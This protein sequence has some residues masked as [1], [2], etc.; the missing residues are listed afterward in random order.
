[1]TQYLSLGFIKHRLGAGWAA[2]GV[3]E[4]RGIPEVGTDVARSGGVKPYTALG[5]TGMAGTGGESN[6]HQDVSMDAGTGPSHR[7]FF[8]GSAFVL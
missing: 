3:G 1:M 8:K 5:K 7:R 2:S 4:E 6:H